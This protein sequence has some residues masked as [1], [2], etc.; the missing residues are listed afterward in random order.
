MHE[1]MEFA[2]DLPKSCPPEDANDREF[3]SIFRAL[4]N[5]AIN[6]K[7][8][9]SKLAC[10]E[11][12]PY[13]TDACRFASCSMFTTKRAAQKML[14]YPKYTGGTLAELEIPKGS[15]ESKKKK[16]HVDFWAYKGFSFLSAVKEIH[17]EEDGSDG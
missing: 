12:V 7:H 2:E 13:G 10:G 16:Q 5:E 15:G 8:F 14:Q 4:P 9:L 6:E 11:K 3:D 17:S 1:L